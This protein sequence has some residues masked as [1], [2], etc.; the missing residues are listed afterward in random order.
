MSLTTTDELTRIAQRSREFLGRS[1]V[2]DALMR[3]TTN[4]RSALWRE[5]FG[6]LLAQCVKNDRYPQK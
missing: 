6:A 3:V 2:R 5:H 4:P 1:D